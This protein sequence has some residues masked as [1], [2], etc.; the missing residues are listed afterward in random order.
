M[1][2][3]FLPRRKWNQRHDAGAFD[4][5]RKLTLVFGAGAMFLGRIDFPEGIHKP[6]QEVGVLVVDRIDL[7]GAEITLFHR[8]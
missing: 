4:G 6:T 1:F 5:A 2:S 7:I 3:C 8:G